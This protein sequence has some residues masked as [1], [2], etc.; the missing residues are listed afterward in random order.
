MQ[1]YVN[2]ILK[3]NH[4]IVRHEDVKVS[5]LSS[6]NPS[7]NNRLYVKIRAL[8]PK[9]WSNLPPF[10][11]KHNSTVKSSCQISDLWENNS[12]NRDRW[13]TLTLAELTG[14]VS[15]AFQGASP[16][17]KSQYSHPWSL[18]LFLSFY[19]SISLES[20]NT[21][22]VEALDRDFEVVIS[23]GGS[24]GESFK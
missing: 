16:L 6:S 21:R 24:K 3:F 8:S 1:A 15:A 17:F 10:S 2:R 20:I 23:R 12:N 4:R 22:E 9:K 11:S 18:S 19:L 5:C 7:S 13:T 14:V